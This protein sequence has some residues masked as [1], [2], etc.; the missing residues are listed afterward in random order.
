MET[1]T[2]PAH[3]RIAFIS[4]HT[5]LTPTQFNTEY[6]PLINTAIQSNHHF[7][8]GDAIG[9]DTFALSYFLS[10]VATTPDLKQRIT[11]YPSR[12][13]N[14]A[15]LQNQGFKV[16]PPHQTQQ[17]DVGKGLGKRTRHIV[18][19]ANMTAASD[20]DIL[21]VRTDGEAKALYGAKWRP[22][23]SATE[24]NRLRR[25]EKGEGRKVNL[26][27]GGGGAEL[28][29]VDEEATGKIRDSSLATSA[30]SK[31]FVDDRRFT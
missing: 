2:S 21:Y 6:L 20:Y 14:V 8:L 31:S 23:V 28:E 7:I 29:I 12:P 26:E 4:G 9:T 10:Q 22:R 5:D 25:L 15:K 1:T 30:V 11:I 24:M 13:S 27:E 16:V 18:R 19:D 3:P 17:L